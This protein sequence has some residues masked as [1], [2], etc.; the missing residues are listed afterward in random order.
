MK[1][2]IDIHGTIDKM[3]KFFATFSQRAISKGHEVHIITGSIKTPEIEK[4]LKNWGIQ[5]THFFSVSDKLLSE[6]KVVYWKTPKDPFFND[7]D[8]NSAKAKYCAEQKIDLH[9]DDSNEYGK[10]FITLYL[11]VGVS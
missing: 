5:Y 2:G 3:S 11:K 9:F 7:D 4:Q 10:F 8:W 1:F 6:E